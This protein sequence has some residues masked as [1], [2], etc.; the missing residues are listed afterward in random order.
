M[1]MPPAL[2]ARITAQ[3]RAEHRLVAVCVVAFASIWSPA[4]VGAAPGG[5]S[6]VAKKGAPAGKPKLIPPKL[7]QYVKAVYPKAM[8]AKNLRGTV[9]LELTLSVDGS[10]SAAVVRASA[11]PEFDAAALAAGK[12]LQFKPA[13][14][15]GKPVSVRIRFRYVFRPIVKKKIV[16]V[17]APKKK[18]PAPAPVKRNANAGQIDGRIIE[19]GTSKPVA[20]ALVVLPDRA[21]ETYSDG[22]GRFSFDNVRPGRIRLYA[23]GADHK[24][25]RRRVRVRARKAAKVLMRVQRKSYVA[26]RATATAPPEPGQVARRSLSK[27]EIE[28]IPGVNGDSFKVVLNLPGVGR[29]PGGAGFFIVRG[30]AP[31][32]SQAVVDGVLIPQLYHFGGIYSVF[33]TDMLEGVDFSPSGYSVRFGRRLG[34]LVE[35]RLRIPRKG[36]RWTGY[37]ETN[38]FHTG[39]YIRGPLTE[40]TDIAV[41]GRR[42]YIDAVL[43]LLPADLLPLTV[44]PRYWDAQIKLDHRFSDKTSLTLFGF[45]SD[46][47][48]TAVVPEPPAAFPD[49]RGGISS[50]IQFAGLI[51]TLRHAGD[52]WRGKVTLALAPNNVGVAVGDALSFD[53]ASTEATLR[54]DMELGDGPVRLRAGIDWLWNPYSISLRLPATRTNGGEPGGGGGASNPI[55]SISQGGSFYA[56]GVWVDGVFSMIPGLDVVFGMRLDLFRGYRDGKGDEERQ[57]D[58]I[59]DTVSPRLNVRYV[60]NKRWTLKGATGFT[61]QAPQPQELSPRPFGTPSLNAQ[62]AFESTVGFEHKI[63]D[64]IDIDLQVFHKRLWNMVAPTADNFGGDVYANSG[65]GKVSGMELL[66]RHKPVGNFFGWVSYTLQRATRVTRP[67]EPERLFGWDQTHILTALGSYKLPANWEI[68]ARWRYVTGRPYTGVNTAVWNDDKDTWSRVQSTCINCER[69]PAFHQLDIRVDKKFI[70]DSWLLGVYLDLQNA[71]NR[72]NPEGITY[73]YDARFQT[74]T[75]GLPII[76]S[77]GLRGEF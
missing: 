1:T 68:G 56:P 34:G 24:P 55:S 44:A 64:A 37:I 35:S 3:Q 28:R 66:L 5:G 43:G 13:I 74:V 14:Y 8:F 6:S 45:V 12:K 17:V 11:G 4:L 41:A 25:L 48:L 26:Y 70:F 22:A 10:V 38:V 57:K 47:K 62:R 69:T 58:R 49:A 39:F 51:G 61:S 54:A 46:D 52:E 76:P 42:S 18:A 40:N 50:G 59:D 15:G 20:G 27:Q 33:N 73:S 77:F 63:S 7:I 23:P 31:Q 9:V 60:L 16:P 72:A 53:L 32:D 71:Y 65:T 30:S 75:A 21:T 67:G 36:E 19:R 29:P 2:F